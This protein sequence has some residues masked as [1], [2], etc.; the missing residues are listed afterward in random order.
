M[1]SA[2]R[3]A[4]PSI[5]S[6]APVA[7]VAFTLR[8]L[9]PDVAI[10]FS[11]ADDATSIHMANA[12]GIQLRVAGLEPESRWWWK[13]ATKKECSPHSLNVRDEVPT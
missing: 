5:E 13:E 3:S 4:L 12:A 6:L 11:S 7:A 1:T 9:A 2:P 10:S 8:E